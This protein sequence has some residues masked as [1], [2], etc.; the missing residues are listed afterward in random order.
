[1]TKLTHEEFLKAVERYFREEQGCDDL[2]IIFIMNDFK[3]PFALFKLPYYK[4]EYID[5][6][7]IDGVAYEKEKRWFDFSRFDTFSN[8]NPFIHYAYYRI[9]DEDHTVEDE[10]NSIE[11]YEIV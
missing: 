6:V 2:E 10:M 3:D 11:F 8:E 9:T 4:S 5:D 7:E 1:M